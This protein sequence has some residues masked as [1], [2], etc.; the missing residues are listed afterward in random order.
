MATAA[1]ALRKE[2][3][4]AFPDVLLGGNDV[5]V[6]VAGKLTLDELGKA[7]RVSKAWLQLL[8]GTPY[9]WRSL[10]ERAW[11]KKEYVPKSLRAL[12]EGCDLEGAAAS[13]A[14]AE[15]HKLMSLKIRELQTIMR[16]L[17]LSAYAGEM[18]E[19]ADFAQAILDAR[20]KAA[21]T[22]TATETL[23][24]RPWA[25]C[26]E[27]QSLPKAALRYSLTDA[28]RLAITK[29][30]LCDLVFHVRLRG[31]GPLAHA[32]EFDPW[33]QGKGCGEARFSNDGRVQFSWPIDTDP[34]SPS[35]GEALNPF[36]AMGMLV[37]SSLEWD[38]T[39]EGRVVQLVIGEMGGPQELVCRHPKTWGWVLY[40]QATCWTSWEMPPCEVWPDGERTSSDPLLADASLS[41]L[42]SELERDF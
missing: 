26:R 13:A 37:P 2:Q 15:H 4:D 33:W 30:E 9:L 18:I 32:I 38:L 36:V 3:L 22:Y 29:E 14:A 7:C 19:K 11:S 40:S 17:S 23:L 16:S 28:H 41:G 5:L 1:A 8:D 21:E 24:R 31:D 35:C 27:G 12:A 25:L 20:C 39:H 10:C 6:E 42:P 34:E